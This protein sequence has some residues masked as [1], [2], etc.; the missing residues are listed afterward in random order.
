MKFLQDYLN[1]KSQTFGNAY[2]SAINAGFTKTYSTN[3]ASRN[4]DW[5]LENV[6][7]AT[8]VAKAERNLDHFLDLDEEDNGKLRVKFDTTKF[9]AERLNRKVYGEEKD[10]VDNSVKVLVV[11]ATLIQK[12]AIPTNSIPEPDSSA[13][14]DSKRPAQIQS[15]SSGEEIREN[16]AG[17]P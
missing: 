12:N 14:R 10:S 6:N 2:Q 16:S 17:L 3:M 8:M 1:P 11:P 9:V 7:R 4:P 15:D 13:R 5:M